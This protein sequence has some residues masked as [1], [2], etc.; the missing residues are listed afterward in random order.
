MIR[1]YFRFWMIMSKYQW[2]FTKLGM[3]IDIVEIWF[4][5]A[6]GQISSIFDSLSYLPRT[7]PYFGFRTITLSNSQQIFTKLICAL[8]LW[9]SGLGLL[10]GTFHQFLTELSPHDMIKAGYL[11]SGL[12]L[13]LGTFHQF[14][15]ELSPHDMIKAGYLWRSGLGL[16]LGT[17]HQFLTELSPHD[18]VKVGYLWR[19]GLG[20]LLGTFHQFLTVISP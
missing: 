15:T 3:C 7:H 5:I 9:R 1:P 13:L 2:I 20:L 12:G 16:L 19:S 11:R 10:L 4:G 8:I 17:F 14:L 18:M 6:K